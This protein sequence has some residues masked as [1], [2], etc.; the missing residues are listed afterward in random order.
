MLNPA[1]LLEVLAEAWTYVRMALAA[2]KYYNQADTVVQAID[3][4]IPRAQLEQ[5]LMLG[6]HVYLYVIG[7]QISKT[8]YNGYDP[9]SDAAVLAA[10]SDYLRQRT[11]NDPKA[12]ISEFLE[13]LG[14][15]LNEAY[16]D[17][18]A[19][20][21]AY[22]N[23]SG[24]DFVIV[25]PLYT[26]FREEEYDQVRPSED[27][28][29]NLGLSDADW[30]AV[31]HALTAGDIGR[32]WEQSLLGRK[33]PGTIQLFST[34]LGILYLG[35]ERSSSVTDTEVVVLSGADTFGFDAPGVIVGPNITKPREL[36]TNDRSIT[37]QMVQLMGDRVM[38]QK[39]FIWLENEGGWVHRNEV[40]ARQDE[41]GKTVLSR[42]R[43]SFE[44]SPT[45]DVLIQTAG[46]SDSERL[47]KIMAG[48]Q[49]LVNKAYSHTTRRTAARRS[50]RSQK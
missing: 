40:V 16:G 30:D 26:A 1:L 39:G 19:K 17:T 10:I 32:V 3:E 41:E 35:A 31:Y 34:V 5:T 21:D 29:E 11:S 38:T 8:I 18:T 49:I 27:V 43:G 4:V 12:V 45:S 22:F 15:H 9:R 42:Q 24:T 48:A 13:L 47:A 14:Y 33:A 44:T 25:D 28:L 50:K 20:I 7:R 6:E 2:K 46:Q 23:A 36:L 37:P